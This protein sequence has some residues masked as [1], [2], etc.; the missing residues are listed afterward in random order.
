MNFWEAIEK[1]K[2]GKAIRHPSWTGHLMIKYY[3]SKHGFESILI[4]TKCSETGE[5][6][7]VPWLAGVSDIL[8]EDWAVVPKNEF[9]AI[10]WSI[11]EDGNKNGVKWKKCSIEDE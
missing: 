10:F 9:I 3:C 4:P 8:A 11:D 5:L 2:E 6:T 7:L 1:L